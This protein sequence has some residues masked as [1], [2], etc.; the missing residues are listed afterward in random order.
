[1]WLCNSGTDYFIVEE[2]IKILNMKLYSIYILWYYS[3]G[4]KIL[5]EQK[6]KRYG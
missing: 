5:E 3:I 4:K 1:M 6:N 2:I